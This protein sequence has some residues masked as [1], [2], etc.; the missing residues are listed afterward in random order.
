MCDL[1]SEYKTKVIDYL[2]S[3]YKIGN[4]PNP[5]VMCNKHIKFDG[6]YNFAMQNG[7]D[8]IA[9]GHYAKKDESYSKLLIPKDTEK[10]Q[11]YF[12][13]GMKQEA[14][15]KT[16]FPLG[17]LKKS[18]VRKIAEKAN[19]HTAIKKDSQ[20]LCFIGHIDLKD[21]LKNYLELKKGDVLDENGNVIGWHEGSIGYTIGQRHGFH[22]NNKN[23]NENKLYVVSKNF[24]KNTITLGS[25]HKDKAVKN[26]IVLKNFSLLADEEGVLGADNLQSKI[27]YRGEFLKISGIKK[28]GEMFEV[29]I[30]ELKEKVATGQM[31]VLYKDDQCLGGGII[32]D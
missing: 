29:T 3:E 28:N 6:F 22:L 9:T 21:F 18:E 17:D 26:L 16:L 7:A 25:E 32:C 13:A 30:N 10:D 5:D 12:L 4:T 27:R 2:I 23:S 1:E 14:L 8:F 20:G 24:E 15:N 31:L 19:L 11:T